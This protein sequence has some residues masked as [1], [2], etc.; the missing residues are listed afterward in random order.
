M[1]LSESAVFNRTAR[2]P[3]KKCWAGFNFSIHLSSP[4]RLFMEF[5]SR[6]RKIGIRSW[7]RS[8]RTKT[9]RRRRRRRTH[10]VSPGMF[11]CWRCLIDAESNVRAT[12]VLPL[13]ARSGSRQHVNCRTSCLA[14]QR[15]RSYPIQTHNTSY[16]YVSTLII[17]SARHSLGFRYGAGCA[18]WAKGKAWMELQILQ[19][20]SNFESMRWVG[21]SSRRKLKAAEPTSYFRGSHQKTF[22]SCYFAVMFKLA[23]GQR[24]T[25]ARYRPPAAL[26]RHHRYCL[27]CMSICFLM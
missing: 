1:F 27:S 18:Q 14:L 5:W 22:Y 3:W 24:I 13:I 15:K 9:R 4:F 26:N 8:R 25:Y 21:P 23:V 17:C 16:V 7:S 10:V 12:F 19:C 20:G 11:G 6:K 2:W